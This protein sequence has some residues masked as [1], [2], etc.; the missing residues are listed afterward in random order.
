[1]V[2]RHADADGRADQGAERLADLPADEFGAD[3]VRADQPVRPVLLG[4]ADRDDDALG[5][6]EIGV[7]LFPGLQM[8]L[9]GEG[10]NPS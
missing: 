9:H 8:Q 6:L 4:R 3:R 7:D 10:I 2:L 5:V 1:M